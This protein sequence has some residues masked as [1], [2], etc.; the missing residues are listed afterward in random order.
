MKGISN[1]KEMCMMISCKSIMVVFGSSSLQY[2]DYISL[3]LRFKNRIRIG[4]EL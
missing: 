1:I 3:L 4:C 2:I